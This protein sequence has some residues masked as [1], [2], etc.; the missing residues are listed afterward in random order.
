MNRFLI[1]FILLLLIAPAIV[2]GQSRV[3]KSD[4]KGKDEKALLKQLDNWID[5]LKRSDMN[6]LN[7]ILAEDFVNLDSN[8]FLSRE[9]DLEPIK[10]GNLKF[11]SITMDG[12]KVY[13]YGDTA[14]VTGI[15][16]YQVSFKG[17]PTTFREQ[18][19]DIYQKRKGEWRVIASRPAP[20]EK[21]G[22]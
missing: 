5:A 1:F 7:W 3:N 11:E 12:V 22:N 17:Q 9:Q 4:R 18:F 19:F 6:A 14:F 13:V 15:G 10:S 2:F 16:V 8:G 21:R 20:K